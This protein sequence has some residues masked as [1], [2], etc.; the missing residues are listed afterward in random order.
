MS[1]FTD[2]CRNVG[3]MVHNIAHPGDADRKVVRKE[4]EEEK[5]GNVTLRR[6]TIEE[7]EIRR[8]EPPPK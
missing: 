5:R 2:I 1:W 3:L 8:D 6:T 4:T 7:I